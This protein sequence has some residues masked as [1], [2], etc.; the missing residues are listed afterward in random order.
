MDASTPSKRSYTH[1]DENSKKKL[2]LR[3]A[4]HTRLSLFCHDGNWKKNNENC[5]RSARWRPRILECHSRLASSFFCIHIGARVYVRR[6]VNINF[7]I[8]IALCA[9][10]IPPPVKRVMRPKRKKSMNFQ[11]SRTQRKYSRERKR[12]TLT[13]IA[14]SRVL[15]RKIVSN[16]ESDYI[17]STV[18]NYREKG[19]VSVFGGRIIKTRCIGGKCIILP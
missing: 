1:S 13:S 17:F 10:E 5:H 16:S 14:F 19:E 6:V 7:E 9:R 12:E 11:I 18:Y 2:H 15:C 3:E 8:K 4:T